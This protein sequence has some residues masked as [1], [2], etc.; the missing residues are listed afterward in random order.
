M[1]NVFDV[2][3]DDLEFI[4]KCNLPIDRLKDSSILVTG[5]YGIIG[6]AFINTMLYLNRK[7]KLNLKLYLITRNKKKVFP[8]IEDE[9]IN[10]CLYTIECDINKKIN[11][12]NRIDFIIHSAALTQSESFINSPLEVIQTNVFGMFS[13]MEFAKIK[14]C[15]EVIFLSTLEIYG[16][17]ETKKISEDTYGAIDSLRVRNCYPESKKLAENVGISY[18][19]EYNVPFKVIRL[20]QTFG[21]NVKHE[22]NRV[23][24]QFARAVEQKRDI[25]LATKGES[26]REYLY[27]YEAALAC[28]YVLLLGKQGEAYNVSNSNTYC[29]IYEMAKMVTDRLACGEIK[30]IINSGNKDCYLRKFD[31]SLDTSKIRKLGWMPFTNLEYMFR[32]MLLDWG[33]IL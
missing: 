25:I 28:L 12:D 18:L 17:T 23:F 32:K 5:A 3:R 10:E 11:I 20:T 9:N 15:R 24:A 8:F 1:N 16:E 29:S 19:H 27:S 2:I 22:D 30:I 13:I 4:S 26:K 31:V 7:F 21:P 33:T 14:K 6:S